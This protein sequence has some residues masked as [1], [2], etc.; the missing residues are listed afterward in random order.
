[1]QVVT[2]QEVSQAKSLVPR[3]S[4]KKAEIITLTKAAWSI[5][6][7]CPPF[8]KPGKKYS[9]KTNPNP[10]DGVSSGFASNYFFC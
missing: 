1:M 9:Q 4:F 3:T 2:L 10:V 8:K 6:Y 5:P 7:T